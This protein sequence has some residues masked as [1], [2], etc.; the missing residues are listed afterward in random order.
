[1]GLL[2]LKEKLPDQYK[3]TL[4]ISNLT[5]HN[6]SGIFI[7]FNNLDLYSENNVWVPVHTG[8]EIQINNDDYNEKN[9]TGMI[10]DKKTVYYSKPEL[11]STYFVEITFVKNL[12]MVFFNNKLTTYAPFIKTDT[13]DKYFG[14]QFHSGVNYS[15]KNITITTL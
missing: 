5:T 10:Y 1:M 7:G 12:L 6:N 4:T 3:I 14:L 11:S 2:W 13:L 9:F 8:F 15:Y